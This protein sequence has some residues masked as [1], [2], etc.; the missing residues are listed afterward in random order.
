MDE[1]P[2]ETCG[3]VQAKY[4]SNRAVTISRLPV[5]VEGAVCQELYSVRSWVISVGRRRD[6]GMDITT[7]IFFKVSPC[8]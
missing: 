4:D 2:G 5:G 6:D 8:L 1:D 7:W 3:R